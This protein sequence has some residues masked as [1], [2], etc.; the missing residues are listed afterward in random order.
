[1]FEFSLQ[2]LNMHIQVGISGDGIDGKR[3]F[4]L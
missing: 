4:L 2:F 3:D 1:M